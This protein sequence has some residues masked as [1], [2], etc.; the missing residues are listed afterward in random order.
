[1]YWK[2]E[3]AENCCDYQHEGFSY[4]NSQ[5]NILIRYRLFYAHS[6]DFPEISRDDFLSKK[7][8]QIIDSI[9]ETHFEY[10]K[11]LLSENL[12]PEYDK[13]IWES[14][15][16]Q[17]INTESNVIRIFLNKTNVGLR[18]DIGLKLFKKI[19]SMILHIHD[20]DVDFLHTDDIENIWLTNIK[21]KYCG[22]IC[23]SP[24]KRNDNY[25]I[26]EDAMCGYRNPAVNTIKCIEDIY[27]FYLLLYKTGERKGKV[28]DISNTS[29][30]NYI[31]YLYEKV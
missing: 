18:T 23:L 29:F 30:D 19:N 17:V 28:I 16:K 7:H 31:K 13:Y 12:K 8:Q 3:S 21:N 1:M 15:K 4:R 10:I 2:K 11:L 14:D 25:Y 5:T 22:Y 9:T 6:D 27:G 26:I 24:T 20:S